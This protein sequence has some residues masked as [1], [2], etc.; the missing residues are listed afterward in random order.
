M[1]SSKICLHPYRAYLTRLSSETL[2]GELVDDICKLFLL[3]RIVHCQRAFHIRI[4]A[5]LLLEKEIFLLMTP[6]TPSG[7]VA[8]SE[9]LRS[10]Y[11]NYFSTRFS[12]A[13]LLTSVRPAIVL[14]GSPELV[15]G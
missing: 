6:G 2:G 3:R 14:L 11:S 12:R 15:R 8:F 9:F 7:F 5:Y 13:E 4:H 10:T 1:L